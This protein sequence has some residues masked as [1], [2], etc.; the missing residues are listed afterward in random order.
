MWATPFSIP[1]GRGGGDN[2]LT[3]VQSNSDTHSLTI[4]S[5]VVSD[6]RYDT[7]GASMTGTDPRSRSR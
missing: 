1:A 2:S 6:S 3:F 4:T 5:V 7:Y